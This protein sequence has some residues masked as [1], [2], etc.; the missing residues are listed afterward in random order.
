MVGHIGSYFVILPAGSAPSPVVDHC[1]NAKP[2]ARH[3]SGQPW[4]LGTLPHDQF[5]AVE[6]GERRLAVIGRCPATLDRLQTELGR[7]DDIARLDRIARSLPG[8]FHLAAIVGDRMRVQG[9]A[10]GL[11]RVFHAR[12]GAATLASDRSDVLA[13]ILGVRPDPAVLALRMLG[14]LPYPLAEKSVWPGVDSVPAG[15]CLDVDVR[16][17]APRLAQWWYPPEPELDLQTGALGLREALSE[18]VSARTRDASVI[19]ADLSGGLDSTPLC[20]LA[21]SGPAKVVAMT[22]ASGLDTDDDLRWARI[23]LRGL[24][25]LKHVVY[26]AEELPNFY[27]EL[28]DLPASMDE[29]SAA[30]MSTA[31]VLARFRMSREYGSRLHLDGLGGDQILIGDPSLYHDLLRR[32]PL[33]ALR[34]VRVHQLLAR[35]PAGETLRS[36]ADRRNHREWFA[37]TRRGLA[38]G[39]PVRGSMFGWDVL[40]SFGPWFTPEARNRVLDLFDEAQ[41]SLRPLAPSRGRHADLARLRGA[42]TEIRLIHQISEPG[43]PVAESPFLDD[44]VVDAC[45]R[46]RP[47]ERATPFEFKPLIKAAMSGIMPDEFL[48]RRTKTDG[49]PLAAEGFSSHSRDIDRVWRNSRLAGLGI[50]DPDRLLELAADQYSLRAH[51][52]KMEIPLSVE[53]WLRSQSRSDTRARNGKGRG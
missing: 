20:A 33:T 7:L 32:R 53:L 24:P 6:V 10:S 47:E 19:S 49:S 14:P 27:A 1:P 8:S 39:E 28:Y 16:G 18:A 34:R 42:A 25:E 9:S 17:H 26:S 11:R 35:F 37:A 43:G 12:A 3:P 13:A 4:I 23:A 51:N 41:E 52:W 21:A 31:R 46:V 40:P 30:L 45:L 5:K 22:M 36:L 44:R 29:P 48:R 38:S 15:H 2:L 50:L